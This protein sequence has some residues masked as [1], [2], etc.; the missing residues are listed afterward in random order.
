MRA[1]PAIGLLLSACTRPTPVTDTAAPVAV[2]SPPVEIPPPRP[3][4][5]EVPAPEAP[6]AFE[7][8]A[9]WPA[10]VLY[11]RGYDPGL[12]LLVVGDHGDLVI[13][14]GVQ[15]STVAAV[16]ARWTETLT[17]GGY[18]PREPCSQEAEYGCVWI[19][20]GRIVA[21]STAVGWQGVIQTVVHWLPVGH[22][23]AVKLPGAC[24]APP[25][26]VR[27]ISVQSSAVDQDGEYHEG[28]S[29]WVIDTS[30]GADL[31]GDGRPELYVPHARTGA[32]PWDIPHDVYVMRGE[33]G[34]LVG[35]IVGLVNETTHVARFEHGLRVVHT[36]AEWADHGGKR[37][38]PTHHT[39]TRSY[40]FDGRR[41]RQ[42]ADAARDG[43]CH[44]C[45]V[46][47][48]RETQ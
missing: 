12:A 47:Y 35:T 40:T 17:A 16:A 31:D 15:G 19:G 32:C 18:T 46:S 20:Q 26:R 4:E 37:P 39:R 41:L 28:N 29:A 7:R 27:K 6:P 2:E 45:G 11:P 34:H 48:C 14:H 44:H 1:F 8:P 33:C 24:V 9:Q 10:E 38:E 3:V 43:I 42:T 13:R 30:A 36:T 25:R 22:T 21:A 23:A 5:I